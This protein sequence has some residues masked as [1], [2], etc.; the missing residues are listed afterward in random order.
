MLGLENHGGVNADEVLK[1]VKEV[2]SDWLKLVV[3]TGNFPAEPYFSIEKTAHLAVMIHAKLYEPDKNG[4]EQRLDYK[5]IFKILK[6]KNYLGYF[7]IEYEGKE[8][9][10]AAVPRGVTYFRKELSKND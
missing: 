9:D 10:L 3:D 6:E 8:D 4:V 7:S 1:M 2:G 5:R